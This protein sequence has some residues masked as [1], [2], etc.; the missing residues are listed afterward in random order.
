MRLI[1]TPSCLVLLLCQFAVAAP[2]ASGPYGTKAREVMAYT[3]KTFFDPKTGVYA[4]SPDD[5]KP[6]YIWRQ[7]AMFSALVGAARHEPAT[8]RPLLATYFRALDTYWDT[9]TPIPAYEPSPTRG[10]GND[11]YYDDNAW[12]VITFAEAYELTGEK[13]YLTRAQEVAKFVAS[14]WDEELGGGIWWHQGHKDNSKNTCANGPAAVG[15]L[16]LARVGPKQQADAWTRSAMKTVEWTNTHLQASD[17][18]FDDRVIVA[19]GEVKK[20]KLTYN[21]A[22]MLRANLELYHITGKQEYLAEAKKIG[23][24]ADWFLGKEQVYRDPLKWSQ[25]MVEADIALYRTT[26]ESY[27]LA[28]A[29][30][31]ADAYYAAWKKEK[32]VEMMSSAGIAR[33]LWLLADLERELPPAAAPKQN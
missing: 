15:Y 24:A 8:Y 20:G 11:K 32:P 33:I 29:K 4:R 9:K 10:N 18:L 23:K 12:L 1:A 28:R 30:T 26:H 7:A 6:D 2:E 14:G 21:S 27:L 19:S 16:Y 5:R 22:L 3:Q 17:G 13:A 25:F 31:N